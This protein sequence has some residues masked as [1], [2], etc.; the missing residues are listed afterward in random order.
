LPN[1]KTIIAVDTEF[2]LDGQLLTVG[3]ALAICAVAAEVSSEDAKSLIALLKA[4]AD[5]IYLCG[6]NVSA[7]LPHLANLMAL[8][9]GWITG[10]RLI[11]S[12]LVARMIDENGGKGAYRLENLL[13][14]IATVKP[15][16][17]RTE[18]YGKFS[19]G[20]PV[21]ERVERC[22][23]DAWASY[24]VAKH[25]HKQLVTKRL[26]PLVS[27]TH[28]IASVLDRIGLI[29][30]FVDLESFE[31]MKR[32]LELDMSVATDRLKRAA[33]IAG[34]GE[35]SPTNDGHIRELLYKHLA[36]PIISRTKKEKL[37]AVD[38]VTLK[39]L[40]HDVARIIIDHNKVEKL[41]SVNGEGL[42]KLVKPCGVLDDASV[43]WLGFHINPLGAR[44]GRRSSTAP[45]SQN[46]P[47]VVRSIVRSRWPGGLIGDFDYRRLE[48]VLLAWI[49]GDEPLLTAFTKGRGYLDIAKSLWGFGVEEGSPEYRATKSVVL[50]VNYNMQVPKMA[51]ELWNRVGVRFSADYKEHIRK[52]A[53]VRARYL[54]Q[55]RPVVKYMEEREQE[56][57]RTQQVRSYT[58]RIRHLP[59]PFGQETP[60]Y[61]HALNQAINYPIQSLASEVTGAALIDIERELL[62]LH[63]LTYPQYYDLLLEQQK[64]YLTNPPG[65]AI[66]HLLPMSL[67][68][69]EVHDSIVIDLHPDYLK[70]DRELVVETMRAVPAL[71]QLCPGF[72]APLDCDAKIGPRWGSNTYR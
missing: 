27:Y 6:H 62:S 26:L 71:H 2:S 47:S 20:W 28:R 69:N 56:L 5:N 60:G 9:E 52:T 51:R 54:R 58:G 8:P 14:N 64:K 72:D 21:E 35:F 57:L 18:K 33:A 67:I 23:L 63:G 19:E 49:S 34:M 42:S 55:H 30:A 13:A 38:L 32:T 24:V 68:I 25:Y 59:L 45:N 48:V 70:R 39:N 17:H 41:W 12:L 10:E 11:D 43:G 61:G 3:G 37:P 31:S 44:T 65:S 29:G 36:L 15:W 50:G 46:W 40:D 1:P 66:M 22:R 4:K 16:K 53:E 7:D